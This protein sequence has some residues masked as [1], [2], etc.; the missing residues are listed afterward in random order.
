MWNTPNLSVDQQRALCPLSTQTVAQAIPATL[1]AYVG[2]QALLVQGDGA[3]ALEGQIAI[4]QAFDALANETW[5]TLPEG[6]Q[7]ELN[8][9]V[10]LGD[11]SNEAAQ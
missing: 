9:A 2:D 6:L 5:I 7:P 11:I 8:M 3:P 10:D 1:L 4:T